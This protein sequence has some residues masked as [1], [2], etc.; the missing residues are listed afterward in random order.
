MSIVGLQHS[1][2]WEAPHGAKEQFHTASVGGVKEVSEK[3]A[4]CYHSS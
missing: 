4:E 1:I 3:V 2:P